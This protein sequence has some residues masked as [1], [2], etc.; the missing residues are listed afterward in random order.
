MHRKARERVEEK[1]NFYRHLSVYLAMS[2]FFLFLN[3][4]TGRGHWWFIYPV[5]GWG[6]GIA[7][8]YFQLFGLPGVGPT[9]SEWE[10]R[11][12]RSEMRRLN[13]GY[14]SEGEDDSLNLPDMERPARKD[15]DED[16]LV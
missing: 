6:I 12:M 13:G 2:V 7:A 5:L 14:P 1:R 10:E 3:I 8:Q 15:W 9:D 11:E 16:E 4:F